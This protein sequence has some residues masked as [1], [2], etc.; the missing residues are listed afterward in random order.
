[1]KSGCPPLSADDGLGVERAA[2]ASRPIK[3]RRELASLGSRQRRDVDP[4]HLAEHR[5]R[6]VERERLSRRIGAPRS[7][8]MKQHRRGIGGAG[9]LAQE[10]EAVGVGPLEIVD[11]DHD[12][13]P[14]AQGG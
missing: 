14:V 10:R 13:P 8:A 3:L 4:P 2:G 5:S 1:M 11:H 12:R 6:H 9:D 7:V